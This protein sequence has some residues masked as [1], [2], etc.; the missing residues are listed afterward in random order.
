MIGL[1]DDMKLQ[2]A[3][4]NNASDRALWSTER[5]FVQ[6]LRSASVGF[7]LGI[8]CFTC[9]EISRSAPPR[10]CAGTPYADIDG[11]FRDRPDAVIVTGM[12]PRASAL[13]DEPIWD[14]LTQVV[15]WAMEQSIPVLWSCLAA[16]AAV[17]YLDGIP[18]LR[19]REKLTGIFPCELVAS[20]HRLAS[21]LPSQWVTPHSRYNGLSASAL[22]EHGYEILSQS[23][24]AGV[25]VFLKEGSARF[26]FLQGHPEYEADTL[27]RQYR[28]DVKR[29][30]LG[31]CN[32]YPVEPRHCAEAKL[33]GAAWEGWAASLCAN[34]L[35]LVAEQRSA[36]LG[37]SSWFDRVNFTHPRVVAGNLM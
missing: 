32:D 28:R 21:G 7:D 22:L 13:E 12:E 20:D 1:G 37:R 33:T 34:W 4:V 11:L 36:S 31:Q 29:F 10:D 3:L 26:L 19:L 18:R 16:H 14:N 30:Q 25:D 5:Q 2:I 23:E 8:Q 27:W 9:P 17:L 35:T 6:M 24:E 15:D